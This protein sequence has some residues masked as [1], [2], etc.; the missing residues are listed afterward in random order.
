MNRSSMNRITM[1]LSDTAKK[2]EIAGPVTGIL[3]VLLAV[4]MMFGSF[5]VCVADEQSVAYHGIILNAA[6]LITGIITLVIWRRPVLK[7]E[8]QGEVLVKETKVPLMLGCIFTAAGECL[9]FAASCMAILDKTESCYGFGVFG[10]A[11]LLFSCWMLLDYRH[12]RI[13]F[14]ENGNITYSD[15]TGRLRSYH[16]SQIGRMRLWLPTGSVR[17]TDSRGKRLFSFEGNMKHSQELLEHLLDWNVE[18]A[19]RPE[20]GGGVCSA[21][22]ANEM[23]TAEHRH[24]KGIRLGA[25]ALLAVI[26]AGCVMS[27]TLLVRFMA[28]KYMLLL[29]AGLPLLMFFYYLLFPQVLIWSGMPRYA[30]EAFKRNHAAVPSAYLILVWLVL[31]FFM[32]ASESLFAVAD[33]WKMFGFSVLIA[34]VLVISCLLRMPGVMRRAGNIAVLCVCAISLCYSLAYSIDL[35]FSGPAEHYA[36]QIMGTRVGEEDGSMHYHVSVMLEDGKILELKV[37]DEIYELAQS[38]AALR[39]CQRSGVF[40]I[41]LVDLHK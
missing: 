30:S 11:L 2:R 26:A 22:G 10:M 6:A 12:R 14:D 19:V 28:L 4:L 33:G 31:L 16:Y 15:F 8:R 5:C 21:F 29:F 39:V 36:A 32:T 27:V 24:V 40:G 35:A 41:R 37:S 18:L 17:L 23:D 7:E 20:E 34:A 9:L 3:I 38:D 13:A 1:G 25:W